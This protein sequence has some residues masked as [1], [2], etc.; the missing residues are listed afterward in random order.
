M[1]KTN[2]EKSE[3]RRIMIG[4]E[5]HVQLK[6]RSKIFCSCPITYEETIQPN[7]NVCPV[8]LGHPG[9]K[10]VLNKKVIEMAISLGKALDFNLAEKCG[11][12]SSHAVLIFS[13]QPVPNS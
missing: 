7:T 6:T 5:I 12:T 13:Q 9:A 2:A 11:F 1:S 4:L 8:C 3:K 10:P